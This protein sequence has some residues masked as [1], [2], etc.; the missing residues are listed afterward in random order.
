MSADVVPFVASA[1]LAAIGAIASYAV[2]RRAPDLIRDLDQ[3]FGAENAGGPVP[4][5]RTPDGI[6]KICIWAADCAQSGVALVG[7][8]V[9]GLLLADSNTSLLGLAYLLVGLFG[10]AVFVRLLFANPDRYV[11]RTTFGLTPVAG[12]AIG[13]NLAMVVV[14][15]VSG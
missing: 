14:V 1:L 5:H 2:G 6:G 13:V 9:A 11:Q 10:A 15:S 7:P 12:L 3:R 4:P 8:P